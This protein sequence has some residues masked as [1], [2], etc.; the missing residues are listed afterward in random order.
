MGKPLSILAA[1]LVIA[2][3]IAVFVPRSPASQDKQAA[4]ESAATFHFS[5]SGYSPGGMASPA[6]P[7]SPANADCTRRGAGGGC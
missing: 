7:A 5:L 6:S 2:L 1:V 3:V 4:S